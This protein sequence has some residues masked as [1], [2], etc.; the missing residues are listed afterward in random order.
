[1]RFF[2]ITLFT[3]CSVFFVVITGQVNAAEGEKNNA[4]VFTNNML[5]ERCAADGGEW[6]MFTDGCADTCYRLQ[7]ANV[8][9]PRVFRSSC[10]CGEDKCW[11]TGAVACISNEQAKEKKIE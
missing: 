4:V 6:T 3:F 10:E 1:M 9:C 8:S 7:K 5:K 2:F 11:D